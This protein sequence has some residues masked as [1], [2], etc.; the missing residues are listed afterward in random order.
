MPKTFRALY[1]TVLDALKARECIESFAIEGHDV[2]VE[3]KEGGFARAFEE[4]KTNPLLPFGLKKKNERAV[5][6]LVLTEKDEHGVLDE[7]LNSKIK[8]GYG[9]K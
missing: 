4:F 6:H 2:R 8:Q 9:L 3:W 1:S 5:L 7:Y